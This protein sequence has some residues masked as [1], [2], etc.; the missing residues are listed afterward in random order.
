MNHQRGQQTEWSWTR[1]VWVVP[2]VGLA[3]V[4]FAATGGMGLKGALSPTGGPQPTAKP[5]MG[6]RGTSGA[7]DSKPPAMRQDPEVPAETA[8]A[9]RGAARGLLVLLLV[10]L[11]LGG[12]RAVARRRRRMQRVLLTPGRTSEAS[13]HQVAGLIEAIGRVTRQRWWSRLAFGTAPAATL[14]LVSGASA[15]GQREQRIAI[16]VPAGAGQLRALRGILASRYPDTIVSP[17]GDQEPEALRGWL[18][19]VVTLQKARPLAPI[20]HLQEAEAL[21]RDEFPQAPVDVVLSVMAEAE[22]KVLVQV[23]LTPVPNVLQR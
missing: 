3:F 6:P 9:L 13:P 16:A 19:E 8:G 17:L 10:A 20:A 18:R 1:A 22:E 5:V 14:E 11:A 12:T 7:A 21:G 15:A 23:V 4:L 2:L